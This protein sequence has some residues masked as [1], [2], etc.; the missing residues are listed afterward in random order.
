MTTLIFSA[1]FVTT[2]ILLSTV[3]DNIDITQQ[4]L[5]TALILLFF[6]TAKIYITHYSA[7]LVTTLILLSTV[8]DN[9]DIT[10]QLYW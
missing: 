6:I 7:L 9:I 3:S 1:L 4:L 2:L 10:Q 5:V 8:S